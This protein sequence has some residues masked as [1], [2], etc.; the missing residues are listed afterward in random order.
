[1]IEAYHLSKVYS[2]GVYALR[3]LSLQVEK[4]EFVFLTGP[5]GAGKSTFLR[6]LLCQ[7]HG[8]TP[9]GLTYFYG[10]PVKIFNAKDADRGTVGCRFDKK[11]GGKVTKRPEIFP[12]DD[13]PVWC[14]DPVT[15]ETLF[16]LHLFKGEP[17]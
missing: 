2:R 12:G 6:L 5:S 17:A 3:E 4:G 9:E 16:R 10:R 8:V 15:A 7:E 14:R 13:F 11:G 1:M